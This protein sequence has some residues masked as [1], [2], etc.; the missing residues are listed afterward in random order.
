MTVFF[1][2]NLEKEIL[3]ELS[4]EFTDTKQYIKNFTFHEFDLKDLG[5]P[6]SDELLEKNIKIAEEV[7]IQGWKSNFKESEVYKGFSLTY[8][9]DFIYSKDSSIYH[10]TFGSSKLTQNFS[11]VLD[12]GL[13]NETKNTYY[14]TYAFRKIPPVISNHLGNFFDKFNLSLLRSRTAFFKSND[15]KNQNIDAWHKDEFPYHLLRIN[16]PLQT[17]EEHVL[18]ILGED[19]F[20]NTLEITN[21]HLETGKLYIWNTRI[22]HRIKVKYNKKNSLPRIHMVLGFSPYFTYNK[23]NDSFVKNYLFGMPVKEL[24]E[25]NLFLK[26]L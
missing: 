20:G 17:S 18:D 5:L 25:K 6:S 21:K 14:D 3:F 7:G 8:N 13:H 15:L 12:E 19:E 24:V 26:T 23:K 2:K 22:P 16:I 9:P 4:K 10:Q 11:R 1:V